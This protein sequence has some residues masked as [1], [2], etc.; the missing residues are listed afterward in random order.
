MYIDL[1]IAID[2]YTSIDTGN[3]T[4]I[5]TS[6]DTCFKRHACGSKGLLISVISIKPHTGVIHIKEFPLEPTH[7]MTIS[8][9]FLKIKSYSINK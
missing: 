2:I 8:M 4:S 1:D 5:D 3:D 9:N 6:I 7:G